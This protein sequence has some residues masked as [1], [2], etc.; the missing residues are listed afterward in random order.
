MTTIFKKGSRLSPANYRPVSLTS[1]PCK[2][3]ESIVRDNLMT[4]LVDNDLISVHQH[5]FVPKRACMTNLLETFDFLT[6]KTANKNSIDLVFLDFAKAFDKV[7]HRRLL[8]KLESLGINGNVL[9]WIAAFLSD[10][11]QRVVMG[12]YMSSWSSVTSGVPQGSVL[13]PTLFVIFVNDLTRVFRNKC[14]LYAR[15]QTNGNS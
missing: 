11:V 2:I 1:V 7:S 14:K 8:C 12:D 10:R 15:L 9:R 13:G 5:G 3:M 6:K 4:H